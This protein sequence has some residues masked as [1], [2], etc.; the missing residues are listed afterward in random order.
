MNSIV[1]NKY[2]QVVTNEVIANNKNMIETKVSKTRIVNT[3]GE[4][5]KRFSLINNINL[6]P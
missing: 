5:K 6:L 3:F 1:G 2:A 4:E